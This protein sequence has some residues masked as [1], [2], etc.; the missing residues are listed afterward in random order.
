MK[1]VKSIGLIKIL[2]VQEGVDEKLSSIKLEE[3][4]AKVFEGFTCIFT[5]VQDMIIGL[6]C[7]EHT[8]FNMIFVNEGS[9]SDTAPYDLLRSLRMVGSRVPV[10][11][12]SRASPQP[13]AD[14]KYDTGLKLGLPPIGFQAEPGM[15]FTSVLK[16]PYTKRDLCD[17]IRASVFC[18]QA[19]GGSRTTSP[20]SKNAMDEEEGT[21]S[22]PSAPSAADPSTLQ[23]HS[24]MSV[25]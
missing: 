6:E 25:S 7:T 9:S 21:T 3:E 4:T 24:S 5:V 13:N 2:Y 1:R 19:R 23:G 14:A 10:V 8:P 16:Q 20:V 15:K 17:V 12:L 22:A 11:L 18:T